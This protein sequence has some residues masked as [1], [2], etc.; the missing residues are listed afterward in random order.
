MG[1]EPAFNAKCDL[2]LAVDANDPDHTLGDLE[3]EK[4]EI[5]AR[6]QREG[7]TELNRSLSPPWD[8]NAVLVVC[9][10]TS[11]PRPSTAAYS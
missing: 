3:A 1:A 2:S 7:L 6:L 10:K 8:Y 11:G 9:R 4:R 5:R